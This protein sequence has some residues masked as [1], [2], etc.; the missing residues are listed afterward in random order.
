MLIPKSS[1]SFVAFLH[2]GEKKPAGRAAL[3]T[4]LTK[5]PRV[6]CSPMFM[7]FYGLHLH[8][9]NLLSESL[10]GLI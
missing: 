2:W 3:T 6:L 1:M 7:L 10:R 9:C 8:S 4:L 5:E